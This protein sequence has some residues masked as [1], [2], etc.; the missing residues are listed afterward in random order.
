MSTNPPKNLPAKP[1]IEQYKKKTKDL[2]KD[3]KSGDES[4]RQRVRKYH[5]RFAGPVET[6]QRGA[7]FL[8]S[9]AQLVIAREQGFE[10]WPK[11]IDSI[12]SANRESK[13]SIWKAAE[14]AVIEGDA[15]TLDRLLDEHSGLLRKK[16][17]PP[18]VPR[19]PYPS[20][21]NGDARSIIAREHEFEN[22]DQFRE[23]RAKLAN[24]NSDV[25][26]FES[27]VD[28]IVNGDL[29]SLKALLEQHPDLIRA[30]SLRAHHSTL[31]HYIGANGIEGFRQKTPPNAVE[32]ATELLDA[33][34]DVN[35][36]GDMYHGSTALGL[37]STS[38]HPQLAGLQDDLIVLLLERGAAMKGAV[39]EDYTEGSA[40]KACLANG[41]GHA[42]ELLASRGAALD[43]EGAAG[44]GN[45]EVVGTF[46]NEDGSLKSTA[47]PQQ[48]ADGFAWACEY[49]QTSVVEFL[50]DR[51]FD[52]NSRLK[53]NGQTGLHWAA[54]GAHLDT[55]RLLLE[56]GAAVEIRDESYGGTP[57]EWAL[58]GWGNVPSEERE[59]FYPVVEA[60]TAAGAK[61]HPRWFEGDNEREA[62]AELARKDRRMRSLLRL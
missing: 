2:V 7:R 3:W 19:G 46:F 53:H 58:Y 49:G 33:G 56:R 36:V 9:D 17:A 55:L 23:F 38:I 42:A 16:Q 52:V 24:K 39:A 20:Y 59:R 25:F 62:A 34:S 43:L 35:A 21:Q 28:A 48:M 18:Y 6:V 29:D 61:F 54:Y 60:L 8:L 5:P 50:L 51:K 47:T 45:L 37:V 22:W 57:L 27:A 41:R 13:D 10:S 32:I 26:R 40:V 31:L 4:A 11:L 44:V 1:D 12:K 15:A 30:H 14:K